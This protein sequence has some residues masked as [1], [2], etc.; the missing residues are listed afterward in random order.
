MAPNIKIA[1]YG[2]NK[3]GTFVG[4]QITESFDSDG[5]LLYID[6]DQIANNTVGVN[7]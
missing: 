3:Y 1:I 7:V 6:N 5:Q 2:F 4:N